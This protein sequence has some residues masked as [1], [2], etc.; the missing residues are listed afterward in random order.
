MA[1]TKNDADTPKTSAVKKWSPDAERDLCLSMLMSSG[2]EIG[3]VA[4]DWNSTHSFMVAMGYEF[5]KDAM[6]YVA[7]H[8]HTSTT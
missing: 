7:A 2:G 6:K 8:I 5:T 4:P 3:K 1:N